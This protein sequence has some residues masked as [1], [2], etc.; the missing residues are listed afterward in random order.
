MT[1]YRLRLDTTTNWALG[2]NVGLA[3]VALSVKTLPHTIF[4]LVLLLNLVFLW[5]ESRRYRVFALI[6]SRVRLLEAGLMGAA[7]GGEPRPTWQRELA[8]SLAEPRPVMNQREACV[9]RLRRNYVWLIWFGFT[10]WLLKLSQAGG[11]LA[12]ARTGSLAGPLVVG[13]VTAS[14]CTLTALCWS[15]RAVEEG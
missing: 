4:G 14:L 7:L 8:L 12:G 10:A 15:Y 13:L 6:R 1:A 2:M 11:V 3:S 9:I 5:M